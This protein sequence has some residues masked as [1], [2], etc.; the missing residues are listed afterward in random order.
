MTELL[1]TCC[2]LVI[3][4]CVQSFSR[5]SLSINPPCGFFCGSNFHRGVVT[6]YFTGNARSL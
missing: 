6:G 3:V 1:F 5:A 2:G 4:V